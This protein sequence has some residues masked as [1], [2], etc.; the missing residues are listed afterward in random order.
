MGAVSLFRRLKHFGLRRFCPACGSR[1]RHFA[2]YGSPARPDARCPIC[3]SSER[4]RAQVLLLQRK[5][6]PALGD[7]KPLRVLHLAPE[8][9]ITT[10]L[11]GLPDVAYISG[12]IEPGRAMEVTD[13]TALRFEDASLDFVFVS[14][15]LEHIPDDRHALR[16]IHRVLSPGGAAFVEV[17][18]LARETYENPALTTPEQRLKAFGQSDHVRICGLDYADRLAEPGFR[19][20]PFWIEQTF[21]QHEID[22]MRL[23]AELSAAHHD[24]LARFDGIFH[25]AWLCSKA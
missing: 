14:H 9:G 1:T 5:V 15:V 19:I 21:T 22:H 7:R 23:R 20:E 12:D 11:R 2:A 25:V 8:P 10:V 4:E 18:V 24:T 6:L 3:G 17:P 16:E 13:L